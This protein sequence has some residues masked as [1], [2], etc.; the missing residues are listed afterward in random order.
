MGGSNT[1]P[2]RHWARLTLLVGVLLAPTLSVP[3]KAEDALDPVIG[4]LG[5]TYPDLVPDVRFAILQREVFFDPETETWVQD[6]TTPPQMWFDTWSQNLGT[7]PLELTADE[8]DNLANSTVSQCVSWRTDHLCREYTPTP[9]GSFTWHDPH[10]HFHYEDFADYELRKFG[11]R[12]AVDYSGRGLIARSEKVSFCLVD[13]EQVRGGA[14]LTPWYTVCQPVRQGIQP[15]WSDIYTS[16]LPG[17][18]FTLPVNIPDGRYALVVT[19]DT[20]N[21]LLES[22][23]SNNRVVVTV[24]IMNGATSVQIVGRSYPTL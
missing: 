6:P 16:E 20:S 8:P 24:E 15:G 19:L 9:V 2:F 10:T 18:S 5:D 11:K 21:R 3:A 23:D 7:V 4:N 1:R 12:G 13:S 14:A 17:Q 22:N